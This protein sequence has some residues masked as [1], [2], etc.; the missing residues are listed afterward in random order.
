MRMRDAAFTDEGGKDE[1]GTGATTDSFVPTAIVAQAKGSDRD[2]AAAAH[3]AAV[4]AT[5]SAAPPPAHASVRA[6][7]A[8]TGAMGHQPQQTACFAAPCAQYK[9]R[10]AWAF[11]RFC[12][13]PGGTSPPPH[14]LRPKGTRHRLAA[15]LMG[16]FLGGVRAIVA[17]I[18]VYC[19]RVVDMSARPP[20]ACYSVVGVGRLVFPH[21]CL[22]TNSNGGGLGRPANTAIAVEAGMRAGIAAG[23]E[24]LHFGQQGEPWADDDQARELQPLQACAD[25]SQARLK[26]QNL[27]GPLYMLARCICW[28]A[29][30]SDCAVA[31]ALISRL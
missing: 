7:E 6:I 3:I 8:I 18:C 19:S 5:A 13:Q 24:Q 26:T 21:S 12:W 29:P 1:R 30:L 22:Q 9:A 25:T 27:L 20:A 17:V 23:Q 31:C 28:R 10:S 14:C 16:V 2:P 11:P 15:Q 4:A